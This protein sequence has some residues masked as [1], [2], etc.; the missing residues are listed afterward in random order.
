MEV[1]STIKLY[2]EGELVKIVYYR[3]NIYPNATRWKVF[4]GLLTLA[5]LCIVLY[6]FVK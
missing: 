2:S 5:G 3:N 1:G 4:Y 6:Q